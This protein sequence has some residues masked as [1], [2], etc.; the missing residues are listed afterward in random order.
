MA[1]L[2]EEHLARQSTSGQD[3]VTVLEEDGEIFCSRYDVA[4]RAAG[5][6]AGGRDLLRSSA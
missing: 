5:R 2:T 4:E 3:R 1:A 6:W